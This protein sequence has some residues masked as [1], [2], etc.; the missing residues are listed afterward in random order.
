[1]KLQDEF[2]G[3][4][5]EKEVRTFEIIKKQEIKPLT[6]FETSGTYIHSN[7]KTNS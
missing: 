5:I 4:K 6:L 3:K 2:N 7:N 1:L